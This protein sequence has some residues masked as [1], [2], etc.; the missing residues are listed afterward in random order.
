MKTVFKKNGV[1]FEMEVP[2][3]DPDEEFDPRAAV[4]T[5][6]DPGGLSPEEAERERQCMLDIIRNSPET[7]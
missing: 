4:V 2:I 6:L 5:L 1:T 3:D 7:A